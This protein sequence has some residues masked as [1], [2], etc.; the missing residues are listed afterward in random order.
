[1]IS[2][3]Q[4]YADQ[5]AGPAWRGQ[6]AV[7]PAAELHAMNQRKVPDYRIA[8][9]RMTPDERRLLT[10]ELSLRLAVAITCALERTRL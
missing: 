1:M 6:L 7:H 3:T 10:T 9:A 4:S 2:S 8:A 5:A